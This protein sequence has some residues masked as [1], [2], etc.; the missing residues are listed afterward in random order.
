MPAPVAETVRRSGLKLAVRIYSRGQY[1][2]DF[3][4]AGEERRRVRLRS[5]D[6]AVEK[7]KELI[8]A[9]NAGKLD[10]M[11]IDR[12]E[13]V[14]FLRWKD[15]RRPPAK[16]AAL[17]KTFLESKRTKGR[18]E[19]HLRDLR[20]TLDVF[21]ATFDC[22]VAA[23]TREQVEA[24]IEA[25]DVGPRRWNNVLS[26]I[27]ALFKFARRDGALGADLHSVELI[28]KKLTKS[29]RETYTPDELQKLLSNA[30]ARDIPFVALGAFCGLRPE[31]IRPDLRSPKSGIRWENFLWDKRKVDVPACVAKD[32]RRRF[33]VLTDAAVA[34][35]APCRYQKGECVRRCDVSKITRRLAKAADIE[36]KFDA[37]RHSYAS[38]RLAM[39]KDIGALAEEMGNSASI[40][41]A[42]YLD[43]KHEEEAE[44]WFAIRPKE[45]G[46]IIS[47]G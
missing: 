46:K 27:I 34:F 19:R 9:T 39:T 17:V 37:L 8:G 16:V 6:A 15:S 18:S 23:L 1:G 7:A 2:F 22:E 24:W 3:Y 38:Y 43:V 33:A 12:D 14:E 11:A 20:G 13:F 41:R 10:A 25:R 45:K 44:E 29:R 32:G 47:F 4:P 42:H 5:L 36:W 30:E 21:G 31:E 35:L 40:I 26:H 28:E